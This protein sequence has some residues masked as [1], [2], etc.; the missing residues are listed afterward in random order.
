M[1]HG[2]LAESVVGKHGLVQWWTLPT[3]KLIQVIVPSENFHGVEEL[4]KQRK[5]GW[6][7]LVFENLAHENQIRVFWIDCRSNYSCLNEGLHL[8]CPRILKVLSH[9]K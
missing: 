9:E 8:D 4:K 6:P 1:V 2:S 7:M 5:Y 3:F